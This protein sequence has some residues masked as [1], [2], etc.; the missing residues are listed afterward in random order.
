[1][2]L[3]VGGSGRD[4]GPVS[5]GGGCGDSCG[6]GGSGRNRGLEDADDRVGEPVGGGGGRGQGTH[7]ASGLRLTRALRIYG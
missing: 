5:G 6:I 4:G 1:M 7:D 3:G 2:G